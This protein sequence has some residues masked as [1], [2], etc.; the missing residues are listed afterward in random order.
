MG[1]VTVHITRARV[2]GGHRAENRVRNGPNQVFR[3]PCTVVVAPR[4]ELAIVLAV[5][6]HL[7]ASTH[8]AVTLKGKYI[9]VAWSTPGDGDS[10]MAL[11]PCCW[12]CS[13]DPTQCFIPSFA[14]PPFPPVRLY[15]GPSP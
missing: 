14:T 15:R 13:Q 7:Q 12:L 10:T 4:V 3:S 11:G 2:G 6:R 8:A 5:A 9:Q 1:M